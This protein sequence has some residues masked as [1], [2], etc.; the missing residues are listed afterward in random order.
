MSWKRRLGSWSRRKSREI[1]SESANSLEA[2]VLVRMYHQ[3]QS[4]KSDI[5]RA[6]RGRPQPDRASNHQKSND[7]H[8][9]LIQQY[10]YRQDYT[11]KRNRKK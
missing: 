5:G 1:G 6:V 7:I 3:C 8:A 10:N 11:S 4:P 2:N 9:I